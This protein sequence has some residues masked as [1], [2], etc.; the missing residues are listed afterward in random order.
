MKKTN[1]KDKQFWGFL[2]SHRYESYGRV[3]Y[4]NPKKVLKKAIILDTIIPLTFF[5]PVLFAGLFY[6]FT[7]G[8]EFKITL[9]D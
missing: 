1:K 9:E 6:I 2:P 5:I 4:I 7:R 8:K 3:K